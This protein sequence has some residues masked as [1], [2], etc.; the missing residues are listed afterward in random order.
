M[1]YSGTPSQPLAEMTFREALPNDSVSA[2][3]HVYSVN[4]AGLESEAAVFRVEE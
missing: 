2:T 1:T 4:S 3:Y